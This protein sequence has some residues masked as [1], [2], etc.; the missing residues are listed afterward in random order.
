MELS[1]VT[2]TLYTTDENGSTVSDSV[3]VNKASN[4]SSSTSDTDTTTTHTVTTDTSKI[5]YSDLINKYNLN[6]YSQYSQSP[7]VNASTTSTASSSKS[8]S[9]GSA[10]EN[11]ASDSNSLLNY[12]IPRLFSA[13]RN[14]AHFVGVSSQ[15]TM[16][17]SFTISVSFWDI[18]L[19]Y[20]YFGQN[21]ATSN[22]DYII[23]GRSNSAIRYYTSKS[24]VEYSSSTFYDVGNKNGYLSDYINTNGVMNFVDTGISGYSRQNDY[25]N[26]NMSNGT[27]FQAQTNGGVDDIFQYSTDGQNI[28]YAKL[29]F[30]DTANSFTYEDNVSYIGSSKQKDTVNITA[31][32]SKTIDLNNGQYINIDNIDARNS[33]GTNK[34]IGN[35]DNNQIFA[36]SGDYLWGGVGGNDELFG[37]GTGDNTFYFGVNEG[38]TIVYNSTSNDTINLYNVYLSDIVSASEVDDNFVLTMT[39]GESLTILGQ[40][41]ASNFI[42]AD[43]SEYVYNRDTHT[44]QAK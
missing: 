6:N 7:T 43:N 22:Y 29:G 3:N 32:D 37:S 40:D 27:S 13:G 11:V 9:G 15:A 2:S 35:S 21:G 17:L 24:S 39:N 20:N 44:W 38:N 42:L 10:Y 25:I 28:S 14:G 8:Y 23:D 33:Q 30:Q 26:F 41:G 34:L 16:T 12:V 5:S 4:N 19:G 18:L 1:N 36:S 31:E